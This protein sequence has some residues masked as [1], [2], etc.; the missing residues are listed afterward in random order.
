MP[1]D[2]D[3]D[4]R[5]DIDLSTSDLTDELPVLIE[6]AVFESD[7]HLIAVPE[8]EDSEHTARVMALVSAEAESI[9]GLKQ[10]L[11]QRAAKIKELER[12]IERLS[13]RW[14]EI[15]RLL[16]EKDAAIG[17]LT[18]ALEAARSAIKESRG[19]ED[20]LAAEI[21]DRDSRIAR[22]LDNADLLQRRRLKHGRRWAAASGA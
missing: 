20:G 6:T 10:D 8:D 4:D 11:E 13:T 22:L 16:N 7:K 17:S 21:A 14:L 5:V 2:P 19:V 9:E 15:E 3:Q 1:I 18:G 12:D